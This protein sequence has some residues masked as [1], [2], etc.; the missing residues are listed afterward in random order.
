MTVFNWLA[1]RY[2]R[3]FPGFVRVIDWRDKT[4]FV[5]GER[6]PQWMQAHRN[7]SELSMNLQRALSSIDWTVVDELRHIP[8]GGRGSGQE[9]FRQ[10]YAGFRMLHRRLSS[11]LTPR[12]A[13]VQAIV[14]VRRN[15]PHFA[16]RYDHAFFF[17][18]ST[19]AAT[20]SEDELAM[21]IHAIAANGGAEP[22]R[23]EGHDVG[24]NQDHQHSAA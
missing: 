12:D 13:L 14:N 4:H 21:E 1:G 16:P 20:L 8:N 11:Q 7:L 18:E 2:Y 5:D 6:I 17:A 19:I 23:H 9:L 3:P 15:H 22:R 10:E 24:I